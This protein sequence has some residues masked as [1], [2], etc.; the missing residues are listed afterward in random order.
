MQVKRTFESISLFGG[1]MATEIYYFCGTGNSLHVA[2]ELQKRLP[3]SVLIPV[4]HAIKNRKIETHADT[5]GIVF[6]IYAVSFPREIGQFLEMLE[7][8]TVP[9]IFAVASR[10]CS[11]PVF[12]EMDKILFRRGGK[13]S[14]TLSVEMPE[15]Y[16]PIFEVASLAE[17]ERMD[18]NLQVTMNAFQNSI[19]NKQIQIEQDKKLSF[20]ISILYAIVC[21]FSFLNRKTRYF[22]MENKFYAN[23]DCTGCGLCQK[24]CLSERINI[25]CRRPVWDKNKPCKLCLACIHYCPSSA[26]QIKGANTVKK[27]RYHHP[28]ITPEAIAAQK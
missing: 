18:S 12:S 4:I 11:S 2:K 3:E 20:F 13:L 27:G 7:W 16:I 24:V 5:I 25:V 15:N 8:N 28:D 19:I 1:Y 22:N 21:F 23:L 17:I 14:A 10:N 26:I 6:P 9:Y